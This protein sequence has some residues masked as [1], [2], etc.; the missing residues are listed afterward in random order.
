MLIGAEQGLA[1]RGC[2]GRA[3]TFVMGCE[4][5][6]DSAI[7]HKFGVQDEYQVCQTRY[8][9]VRYVRA[10]VFPLLSAAP[11]LEWD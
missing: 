6:R 11:S 5:V 2:A 4:N 9:K 3:K 1:L 7:F 10:C 8:I